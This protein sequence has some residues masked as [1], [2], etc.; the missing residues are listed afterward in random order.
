MGDQSNDDFASIP[1]AGLTLLR[2]SFAMYGDE[3]YV[4]LHENPALMIAVVIYVII[5]NIFLA[6]LLIAQVNCSYQS[7]YQDMVGYARLNRGKI[8][9]EAMASV[10]KQQWTR[11]INSLR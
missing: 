8:L 9:I 1:T 5:T 11:F 2:I 6:N 3:N 10:S 4:S 7:T